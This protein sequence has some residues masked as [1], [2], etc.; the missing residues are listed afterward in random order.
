MCNLMQYGSLFM[1]RKYRLRKL[2]ISPS[3]IS[4]SEAPSEFAYG[5]EELVQLVFK[6]PLHSPK[7]Y[8]FIGFGDLHGPK[9]YKFIGF[10]DLQGPK[11]PLHML[12]KPDCPNEVGLGSPDRVPGLPGTR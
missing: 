4:H 9:P 10:G 12:Y 1:S 3:T 8:K 11:I 7:T 5:A 6:I 2:R